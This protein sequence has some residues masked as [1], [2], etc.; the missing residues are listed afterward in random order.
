MTNIR[1]I[2]LL[3]SALALAGSFFFAPAAEAGGAVR[4]WVD[5]K[6]VTHFSNVSTDQPSMQKTSTASTASFITSPGS[7]TRQ[8]AIYKYKDARGVTHYTDKKPGG[9]NRYVVVSFFCPACDPKSPIN[10]DRT[11]LNVKSFNSEIATAAA[12]YGVDPALVRAIIHAESAFNPSATSRAGAQG[13]MQLMPG[14]AAMYGIADSY[15]AVSNIQ[16]GTQHLAML[17]KKYNGDV[18]LASAA[19]NAGEGNVQ[20]YGGV[21]PFAETQVYVQRVAT[22]FKRYQDSSMVAANTPAAGSAVPAA[23]AVGTVTAGASL[24]K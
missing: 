11:K 2:Q 7:M 18:K 16:G 14:T 12:T 21:P 9:R 15:D 19:Y 3:L 17:L 5:S 10:W 6:G 22:L 24:A 1:G 13:L 4:K 8:R 20:K 23:V